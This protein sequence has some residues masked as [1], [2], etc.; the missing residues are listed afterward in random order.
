MQILAFSVQRQQA[1]TAENGTEPVEG[2][3]QRS[4]GMEN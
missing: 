4:V 1:A 2:R 3:P